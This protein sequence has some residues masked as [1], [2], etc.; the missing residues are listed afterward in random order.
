[1]QLIP[2]VKAFTVVIQG[3]CHS[4]DA[5]EA[6]VEGLQQPA[7]AACVHYQSSRVQQKSPCSQDVSCFV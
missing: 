3:V 7:T 6:S 1:M 2:N 5:L 4:P